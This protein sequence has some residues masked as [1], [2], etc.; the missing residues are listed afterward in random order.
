MQIEIGGRHLPDGYDP[1]IARVENGCLLIDNA[2]SRAA[3]AMSWASLANAVPADDDGHTIMQ[4]GTAAGSDVRY[5]IA[6]IFVNYTGL[7][8]LEVWPWSSPLDTSP[9]SLDWYN[10]TGGNLS[11]GVDTRNKLKLSFADGQGKYSSLL[12]LNDGWFK[13]QANE[14]SGFSGGTASIKVFFGK[15]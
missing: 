1:Q 15:A 8:V 12:R 4:I 2:F 10:T 3:V 6:T 9:S 5:T 13:L 14:S 11:S 7:G